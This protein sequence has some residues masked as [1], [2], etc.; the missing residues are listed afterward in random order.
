MTKKIALT[1]LA[2]LSLILTASLL[3]YGATL[4]HL[5]PDLTNQGNLSKQELTI[6]DTSSAV[7]PSEEPVKTQQVQISESIQK[8]GELFLKYTKTEKG[9]FGARYKGCYTKGDQ[10]ICRLFYPQKNQSLVSKSKLSFSE[11]QKRVSKKSAKAIQAWARVQI[12]TKKCTST[13]DLLSAHAAKL[14]ENFADPKVTPL[15]MGL[16]KKALNCGLK[17]NE[18]FE[19]RGIYRYA[20]LSLLQKNE[21]EALRALRTFVEVSQQ[22]NLLA[23]A[24]YWLAKLEKIDQSEISPV[25]ALNAWTAHPLSYH[26]TLMAQESAVDLKAQI[27]QHK[28][29][30]TL[31]RSTKEESLNLAVEMIEYFESQ[32]RTEYIPRIFEFFSFSKLSE[33]EPEFQLYVIQKMD[34]H[35]Q[36]NH[37]KFVALSRLFSKHPQYKTLE[38]LQMYYPKEYTSLVIENQRKQSPGLIISLMRQ[39]SS[40]NTQT[41]SP[42]GARGLMQIMPRTAKGLNKRIKEKDLHLPEVNIPM[43]IRYLEGL[44]KQFKGDVRKAL[45][46]YNAGPGNVAKWNKRYRTDDSLLFADLIPFEETREYVSTILRNQFWYEVLYTELQ[47]RENIALR[48][49]SAK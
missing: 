28:K 33:A 44:T 46:A 35:M 16:Y 37:L 42:V 3:F 41:V 1:I 5:Q 29:V 47:S 21:K 10:N 15:V 19:E 2:S 26:S 8:S 43:G 49:E 27:L 38:N 34:K 11:A 32:N 23:R 13:N 12:K 22:Q 31:A 9:F 18:N 7:K 48:A 40:F 24:Q 25:D 20:L 17:Q 14:E 6:A 4:R 45:A 30:S 39:E 36:K